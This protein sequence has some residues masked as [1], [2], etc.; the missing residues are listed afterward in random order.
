MWLM[1]LP[2]I[3]VEVAFWLFFAFAV[4]RAFKAIGVGS[5]PAMVF[6]LVVIALPFVAQF[7]LRHKADVRE[8]QR[9]AEVAG[10][11][12]ADFP[13]PYPRLLEIHGYVTTRELMIFL[14]ALDIDEIVMFQSRVHQGQLRA[15]HFTLTEHCRG[16]GRE[17]LQELAGKG[18]LRS[19]SHAKDSC[20]HEQ[21]SRVDGNRQEIPAVLF[22]IDGA[23]TLKL[24]GGI[25]SGGNYEAR[26]RT[27][28][29]DLLLDYWE[30]PFITRPAGPSPWW[31]VFSAN[32]DWKRYRNPGRAK[33]FA[34]AV[35][36]LPR[37]S[38][39]SSK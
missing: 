34:G 22:L 17:L 25:W 35:G 11:A 32:S 15:Q 27:R 13:S 38:V 24:P 28:E 6:W 26:V 5:I 14:D 21:Q 1:A 19:A 3:I 20:L 10:F 16:R 36:L 23:T 29:Q 31:Y 37:T 33:F 39:R 30:R 2:L 4:W 9:A 7:V 8:E 12:R 18:G